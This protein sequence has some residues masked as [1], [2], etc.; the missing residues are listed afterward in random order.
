MKLV[1]VGASGRTGAHV[2]QQALDRGHTVTAVVRTRGALAQRPGLD[3]FEGN[4][5]SY[6]Q[7]MSAVP[8]H[9]A[10]ISCL[11][12]RSAEHP[13]LLQRAS[14]VMLAVLQAGGARRYLVVSQGLLFPESGPVLS[15]LR[16]LLSRYIADSKEMEYLIQN[17]G[18]EWTIARPPQL[19]DG[20]RAR[21]YVAADGAQ[22]EGGRR[23]QRS[24]LA[25]YLLDAVE[26]RLHIRSIVG[27][28]SK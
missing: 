19:L 12:Q 11:G 8:G 20:G 3:I 1:V 15:V 18:V 24:D 21:G 16:H 26:Q 5:L 22:P 7:M 14:E 13:N 2:V 27:V 28:H 23:L 4:P 10:V 6:Q 17:S 9:D 25:T